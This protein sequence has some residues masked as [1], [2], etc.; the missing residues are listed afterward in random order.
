[1]CP[2]STLKV[3]TSEGVNTHYNLQQLD[4]KCVMFLS[5]KDNYENKLGQGKH[6]FVNGLENIVENGAFAHTKQML[7]ILQ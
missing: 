3:Q 4:T 2:V 1:M 6:F 7:N 5:Q